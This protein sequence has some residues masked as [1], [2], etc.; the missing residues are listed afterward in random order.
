M[1]L[2]GKRV[3]RCAGIDIG[4]GSVKI[5]GAKFVDGT[6]QVTAA[7][8]LPLPEG[9]VIDGSIANEEALERTV[10]D[11]SRAAGLTDSRAFFSIPSSKSTF[12]WLSLP[13]LSEEETIAAATYKMQ[14]ATGISPEDLYYSVEAGSNDPEATLLDALVIAVSRE[15]VSSRASLIKKCGLE[16]AGAETEAQ[17]LVRVLKGQESHKCP[18]LQDASV[19]LVDLG[20]THSNMYVLQNGRL[21][22]V[23]TVKFG[24]K[25]FEDRIVTDLGIARPEAGRLVADLHTEITT[26]GLLRME[27]DGTTTIL[28]VHDELQI[29]VRE[30]TRLI[31][32]FR[33][34]HPER[35]YAG[36]L[37]SMILCGGLAGLRGFPDYFRKV[38]GLRVETLGAFQGLQADLDDKSFQRVAD[39]GS[40]FGVALGLAMRGLG[41]QVQEVTDG[42]D[43]FAWVRSA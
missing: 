24:M 34:L 4:N 31:R 27:I 40:C 36:I 28:S 41:K 12:R 1:T 17:S 3:E 9:T 6:I 8:I 20:S 30:F 13:V 42:T 43:C 23:R 5:V 32:Y 11:Y 39:N 16:P 38:L 19:T 21:Q 29:L 15:A 25:K 14:K 18:I 10:R 37:D 33:S 2:R 7:Q 22:F 26:T 35:S